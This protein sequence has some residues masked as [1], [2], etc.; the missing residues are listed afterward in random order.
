V[1]LELHPTACPSESC[2]EVKD[3]YSRNPLK[4]PFSFCL[5]TNLCSACHDHAFGIWHLA[6]TS[7]VKL[8]ESNSL[9]HRFCLNQSMASKSW[10]PMSSLSLSLSLWIRQPLKYPFS[11]CLFANLFVQHVTA[12]LLAFGL[13]WVQ[14]N[15][16]KVI[17]FHI[18]L[19]KIKTVMQSEKNLKNKEQEENWDK[20]IFL[21]SVFL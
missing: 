20:D 15:S 19:Y 16:V 11:F 17:V 9:S 3:Y 18:G 2:W 7:S 14:S 5:F 10:P 21:L 8:C 4:Y 6:W 13:D 1:V 12:M